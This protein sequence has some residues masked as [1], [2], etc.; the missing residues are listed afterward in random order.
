MSALRRVSIHEVAPRD[1]FQNEQADIPAPAKVAL[2]NRLSR[3]G[4]AKIEVSSF[5]SP[6]AIP[7]LRDASDV[8]TAIDRQP[9]V[10]YVGL[11][12]NLRG[13]ERAIEAK[14]DEVNFVA[15]VSEAHNRANMRMSPDQ[16]IALLR[17]VADR[18]TGTGIV[19][20]ATAATAFACPFEGRQPPAKVLSHIE[21]CLKAGAKG[22]TVADTI[23][24]ADPAKVTELVKTI[25]AT[26]A[27]L[28]LTLHLHDT[29]GLAL[30]NA[31]AA[32]DQGVTRFDAALG[33]IGGCP[34]APGATGNV[35]S[36]DMVHMFESMGIASGVDLD[37][38]LSVGRDLPALIGHP[39]PSHVLQAGPSWHA[40]LTGCANGR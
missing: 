8:F 22:I 6:T 11:I 34:F 21:R 33:G 16:S 39:V 4:F 2:I 23:G 17:E 20:H 26:F 9:G 29:R 31:L 36:E 14:V 10:T 18:L 28:P 15:S 38:L 24:A 30:A 1:G 12:P 7:Q 32:F 19:L 40:H 27:D 5:V 3:L 13:A 25:L 37:A 35:A